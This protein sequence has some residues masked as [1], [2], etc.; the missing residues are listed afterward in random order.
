MHNAK[1]I[2]LK[3]FLENA[4]PKEVVIQNWS[5]HIK[6]GHTVKEYNVTINNQLMLVKPNKGQVFVPFSEFFGDHSENWIIA[7][8]ENN[9]EM[10]RQN[11]KFVD[12]ID[13]NLSSSQTK[14][15]K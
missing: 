15:K 8:T 7:L 13:W 14:I 5:N 9:E 3:V 4:E 12:R 6:K 10:F 11:T 2:R 1:S